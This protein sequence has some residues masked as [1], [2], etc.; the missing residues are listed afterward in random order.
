MHS[1]ARKWIALSLVTT[2]LVIFG[3]KAAESRV[4]VQ[5]VSRSSELTLRCG[6]WAVYN[7]CH[8][9]GIP[10]SL[11]SVRLALPLGQRGHT[12][13]QLSDYLTG[14]GCIVSPMMETLDSLAA[15]PFPCIA[16]F[17]N[18]DHFAVVTKVEGRW[19]HYFDCSGRRHSARLDEFDSRWTGVAMWV[20][21]SPDT[22]QSEVNRHGPSVRFDRLVAELGSVAS[23]GNPISVEY[24]FSN[25]GSDDLAI[26]IIGTDCSCFSA[27]VIPP[28]LVPGGHG[29]VR[30]VY[31][32]IPITGAFTKELKLSTNDPTAPNL[33]LR[34]CGFS[35]MGVTVSP[36]KVALGTVTAGHEVSF[37]LTVTNQSEDDSVDVLS[38]EPSWGEARIQVLSP[39]ASRSHFAKHAF[40]RSRLRSNDTGI[41][42]VIELT[43]KPDIALLGHRHEEIIVGT[44]TKDYP[45]ISVPLSMRVMDLVQTFPQVI[46]VRVGQKLDAFVRIKLVGSPLQP[47]DVVAMRDGVMATPFTDPDG[48]VVIH[49]QSDEMEL[50]GD[51][52]PLQVFVRDALRGTEHVRTIPIFVWN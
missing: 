2:G 28:V 22:G 23:A 3:W 42:T 44:T 16:H 30:A 41:E 20:S 43:F 24:D 4:A 36:K 45:L 27:E 8:A 10:S 26:Q 31:S 18:P 33:S 9:L 17:R 32:P 49:V 7:V 1:A 5:K 29:V 40:R 14:V 34:V 35:D 50:N 46:P 13:L 11:D 15:G 25:R 47:D 48:S 6:H 21:K 19:V 51:E 52:M 38:V 12:L 39:D 37:Q